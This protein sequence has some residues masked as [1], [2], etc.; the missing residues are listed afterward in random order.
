MVSTY[1]VASLCSH[2]TVASVSVV[3]A[4]QVGLAA[5]GTYINHIWSNICTI[6]E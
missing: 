2:H 4:G 3:A 1:T 6:D 5:N